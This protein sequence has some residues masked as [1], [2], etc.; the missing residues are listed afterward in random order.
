MVL[1]FAY[2][3]NQLINFKFLFLCLLFGHAVYCNTK[4]KNLYTST[5]GVRN[6][7]FPVCQ[8]VKFNVKNTLA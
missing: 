6:V 4:E 8:F 3:F 5:S 7:F 2:I 1:P